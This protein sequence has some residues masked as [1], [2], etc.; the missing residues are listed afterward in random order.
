VIK[1]DTPIESVSEELVESKKD[2]A[3]LYDVAKDIFG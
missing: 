3:D 1:N 2:K